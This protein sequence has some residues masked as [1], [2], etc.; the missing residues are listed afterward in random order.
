M[1]ITQQDEVV[2]HHAY[3]VADQATAVPLT[4]NHLLRAASHSKM[5]TA[6]A[7]LQLQEQ[8]LL[9]ID[10]NITT[11]I[12]W[13]AEHSDARWQTITLRQLLSH[14]AGAIRDG[15]AAGFWQGE[16]AFPDRSCYIP[17]ANDADPSGMRAK[18]GV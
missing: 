9:R 2:F 17:A 5:F 7:L 16:T 4:T 13:L 12:P 15:T 8:G 1:A 14:S 3:G 11:Y 18:Y 6:T 10:D